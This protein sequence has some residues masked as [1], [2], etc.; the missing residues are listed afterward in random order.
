MLAYKRYY[1]TALAPFTVR[2]YSGASLQP[3]PA[4]IESSDRQ[5]DAFGVIPSHEVFL[6]LKS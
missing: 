5:A 6:C 4:A 3:K 1:E 2:A